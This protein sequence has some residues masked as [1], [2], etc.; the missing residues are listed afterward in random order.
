[1]AQTNYSPGLL[2]SLPG[3]LADINPLVTES[4]Y[5]SEILGGGRFLGSCSRRCA[6]RPGVPVDQPGQPGHL[7]PCGP[8]RQLR[9]RVELG[10]TGLKTRVKMTVLRAGRMTVKVGTNVTRDRA[11]TTRPPRAAGFRRPS[12]ATRSTPASRR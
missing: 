12:W 3:M 6:R 9:P 4:G 8:R 5:N 11:R 1:M 2:P 7:R 10:T